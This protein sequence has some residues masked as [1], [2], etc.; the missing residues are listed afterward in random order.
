METPAIRP[1][2]THQVRAFL[3]ERGVALRPWSGLDETYAELYSL[4]GRHRD[5]PSL[6]EPLTE[7][8]LEIRQG[9]L[10]PE[11]P[12]KL[13]APDA[14]LLASWDVAE[15]VRDLRRALPDELDRPDARSVARFAAGLQAAALGGFLLLGMAAAGC[16]HQPAAPGSVAIESQP[17]PTPVVAMAEALSD[18]AAPAETAPQETA[19]S[20]FAGVTGVAVAE[21]PAPA[22]GSVFCPE[23]GSSEVLRASL[24]G[25]N[26]SSW[27]KQRLCQ[28]L[29]AVNESWVGGL[30]QLFE[31]S[32]PEEIARTL[33]VLADCC[34]A[35][36]E[37]FQASYQSSESHLRSGDLCR[38]E[39]VDAMMVPLYRG[40]SFRDG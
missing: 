25:S 18:E 31:S 6:W 3:E 19:D 22:P 10:A 23:L 34:V 24:A 37:T 13:P 12:S 28:C 26:I 36:P 35:S 40:V 20:L 5:D 11:A 30:T 16:A 1:T 14:E 39:A 29:S 27:R 17:G 21:E 2:V 4:L 33:N 9:V 32:D 15:L 38:R 8:M 7:L